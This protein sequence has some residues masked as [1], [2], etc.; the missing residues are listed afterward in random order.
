MKDPFPVVS[1]RLELQEL[2]AM[3]NDGN[4]A[5]LVPTGDDRHYEIITRSDLI[6]T[7]ASAGRDRTNGK[8]LSTS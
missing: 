3:L 5:V 2:S 7:L 6:K 1:P 4:G 8:P